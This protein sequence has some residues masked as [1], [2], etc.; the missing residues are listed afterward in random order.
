MI[1]KEIDDNKVIENILE[2]SLD[3]DQELSEEED[4][5]MKKQTMAFIKYRIRNRLSDIRNYICQHKITVDEAIQEVHE[6]RSGLS[7][8]N[9]D[10]LETIKPEYLNEWLNE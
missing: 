4:V 10:I 2:K 7:A 3:K 9:R 1:D 6:K 5:W 8:I